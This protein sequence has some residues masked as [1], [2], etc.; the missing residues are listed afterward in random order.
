[1]LIPNRNKIIYGQSL[2]SK[3]L[4][5]SQVSSRR[6][7]TKTKLVNLLNKVPQAAKRGVVSRM[8]SIWITA[9]DRKR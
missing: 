7:P 3:A 2:V 6:L 4:T 1:M 9:P 5:H 8:A